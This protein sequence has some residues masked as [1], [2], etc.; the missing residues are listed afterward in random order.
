[1]PALRLQK[2]Y[3]LSESIWSVAYVLLTAPQCAL[4]R[5][6]QF[7]STKVRVRPETRLLDKPAASG[8]YALCCG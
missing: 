2:A 4:K 8:G 3:Q 7:V 5:R 1:L 6:C